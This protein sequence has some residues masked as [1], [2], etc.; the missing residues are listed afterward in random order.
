M[1]QIYKED[2]QSPISRRRSGMYTAVPVFI[3]PEPEQPV[4]VFID[5]ETEQ[6]NGTKMS[7]SKSE[8]LQN[9][10]S[11]LKTEL[12]E[13]VSI[14]RKSFLES[15]LKTSSPLFDSKAS[16]INVDESQT[17]SMGEPISIKEQREKEE[18]EKRVRQEMKKRA[19]DKHTEEQKQKPS[20]TFSDETI[21]K[22]EIKRDMVKSKMSTEEFEN[23][24]TKLNGHDAHSKNSTHFRSEPNSRSSTLSRGETSRVDVLQ[25]TP[26]GKLYP[27]EAPQKE[28]GF[29]ISGMWSN[30]NLGLVKERS[31]FWQKK[32]TKK[33]NRRS[34]VIDPNDWVTPLP[35]ESEIPEPQ[36]LREL[37]KNKFMSSGN[38]VADAEELQAPPR[39]VSSAMVA[40][41]KRAD[42]RKSADIFLPSNYG[43]KMSQ[44]QQKKH[45]PVV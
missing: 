20:S 30:V 39:V 15:M 24:K 33:L 4:P 17:K 1:Q 19:H 25:Q 12:S 18:E 27:F 29:S 23:S 40:I 44:V 43:H 32:G 14:E 16:E 21:K 5:P 6:A 13:K 34:R 2:S 42:G 36:N 45:V 35:H 11:K 9:I 31:N 7:E 26:R 38:L 28:Q 8:T 3:D 37:H 22:E 10:Q 41:E